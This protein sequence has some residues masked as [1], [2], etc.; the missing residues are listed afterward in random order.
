MIQYTI[1]INSGTPERLA[2]VTHEMEQALGLENDPL[3]ILIAEEEE[4]H[5]GLIKPK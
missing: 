1:S 3:D 4:E 5:E 2:A